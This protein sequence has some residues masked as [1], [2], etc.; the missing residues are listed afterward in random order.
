MNKA[1]FLACVLGAGVAAES[2]EP[3]AVSESTLFYDVSGRTAKELR[4][5]MNRQGPTGPDG[6]R[7][8]AYSAWHVKWRYEYAP[9]GSTCRLKQVRVSLDVRITL[10]RWVDENAAPEALRRRWKQYHGALT[11]H[12]DG[13][14][15][16]GR[17]AAARVLELR[18]QLGPRP[19]C[20]DVESAFART[21]EAILEEERR[22]D[23][24]F[25][26]DTEHGRNRGARF[27]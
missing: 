24:R 15:E 26:L 4:A 7:H 17:R 1:L 11:E 12:E 22:N 23:V 19:T 10:P 14:A 25:D 13:H 18:G 9:E 6:K 27:P 20:P 8:D 5:A 3:V 2:A 21:A 16:N